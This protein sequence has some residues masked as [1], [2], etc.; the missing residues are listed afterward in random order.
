ML[1]I[2]LYSVGKKKIAE[3]LMKKFL[4]IT[5][6]GNCSD[7]DSKGPKKGQQNPNI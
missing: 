7:A 4:K 1:V 5:T 6:W 3:K 2:G